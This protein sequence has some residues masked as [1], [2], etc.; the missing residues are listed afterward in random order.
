M[1]LIIFGNTG[2]LGKNFVSQLDQLGKVG[3]SV[4]NKYG[5]SDFMGM[6]GP[7]FSVQVI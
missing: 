5:I 1:R 3:S 4:T 6:G 2:Q 7:H